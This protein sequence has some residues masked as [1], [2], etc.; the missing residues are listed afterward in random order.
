MHTTINLLHALDSPLSPAQKT[1]LLQDSDALI[2]FVQRDL[3]VTLQQA[4]KIQLAMFFNELKQHPSL[5]RT[6]LMTPLLHYQR[7]LLTTQTTVF[8]AA[9]RFQCKILSTSST[10]A[11]YPDRGG[12]VALVGEFDQIR[13]RT[14]GTGSSTE[15]IPIIVEFK[16]GLGGAKRAQTQLFE[17][18]I[19][20]NEDTSEAHPMLPTVSHAMQL[21]I[22]WLAFQTRWDLTEHMQITRGMQQEIVMPL[23]QKLELVLYN[24]SDGC[25]YQLHPTD[26]KVAVTALVEC[27]FYLDWAL[28]S[29]YMAPSPD[30]HCQGSP[31]TEV[32]PETMQVQVGHTTISAQECYQLARA[33]FERFQ[34]TICWER[35]PTK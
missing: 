2:D 9:E 24:L 35:Y 22:Y 15:D 6:S 7:E 3:V 10:F 11:S 5:L 14:R 28:K 20:E 4:G 27:I 8:S 32:A 25:Q 16:K 13:L 18:A 26:H 12:Y 34:L 21:M 17:E 33:A 23:E 30:H 29:G 31:L 1:A 19:E